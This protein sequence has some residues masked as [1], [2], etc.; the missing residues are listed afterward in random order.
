MQISGFTKTTLLDYPGHLA[1]TV[2]LGGCNFNCPY[3]HNSQLISSYNSASSYNWNDIL[4]VLKKRAGILEGVCITGGEP[5]LQ[6][7]LKYI[8]D[9]IHSLGLK[10]KLDTNGSKPAYLKE[11]INEGL[12]D[13]VAMDIKNSKEE[14]A[15]TI[16]LSYINIYEIEQSVNLLCNS[17]IDYE[18]RTTLV[19]EFHTADTI[20]DIG[21][22]LKD[23]N[24]YYLQNYKESATVRDKSLHPLDKSTILQYQDILKPLIP[25]TQ[26]RG[27]D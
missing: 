23:S 9:S 11:L 21:K 8:L 17:S 7:N 3:C 15:H 5:T 2:F 27:I 14:Y 10:T 16:G 20:L 4:S 22:W 12:I 25:N 26:I 1:A 19:K 13:Y 18:F 24:A 6:P